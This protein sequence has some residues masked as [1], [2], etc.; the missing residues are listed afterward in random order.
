M[1]AIPRRVSA[2]LIER[3]IFNFRLAPEKLNERLPAK[4]LQPQVINGWAVCSFCVLK[5]DRMTLFPIPPIIPFSTL[6][7]AY[8]CGAIDA[9]AGK[10][11][12]TVYITDRNS[13]RPLIANLGPILFKDTIPTVHATIARS[14][15]V[16][17][18]SVSHLDGQRLFSADVNTGDPS[19]EFDSAI[20][21]TME[22]FV[23]FIK[24][25]VSSWTPSVRPHKLARLDLAKD[26]VSYAPLSA[27]VDFNALE[28][29]WRDADMQFDSAVRA[30]GGTYRWT[31]RGLRSDH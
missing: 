31:Y 24:G 17:E 12:P 28:S 26:D 19:P 13:D 14:P 21:A 15:G 20:F 25:G 9:S 8:R 11:E 30:T 16:A 1:I 10:G 5:L 23:T 18:I 22:E 3:F 2:R 27:T 7:C 29:L 4:W 6:S